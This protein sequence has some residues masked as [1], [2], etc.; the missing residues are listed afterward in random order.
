M[1]AIGKTLKLDTTNV[2]MNYLEYF[3]Y[4]VGSTVCVEMVLVIF[5]LFQNDFM[6]VV[7]GFYQI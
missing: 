3:Y 5:F 4:K 7:I 6:N 2:I 1:K